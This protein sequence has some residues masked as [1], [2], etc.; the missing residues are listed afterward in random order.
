MKKTVVLLILVILFF[1]C[2]SKQE[3][4]PSKDFTLEYSLPELKLPFGNISTENLDGTFFTKWDE[5]IFTATNILRE[6]NLQIF[7]QDPDNEF[8]LVNSGNRNI[9]SL[10]FY[11]DKFF[12]ANIYVSYYSNIR[13]EYKIQYETLVDMLTEKYGIPYIKSDTSN[14]WKFKNDSTIHISY[15]I[16][17]SDT[18]IFYLNYRNDTIYKEKLDRENMNILQNTIDIIL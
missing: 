18:M 7:Y 14:V 8:I 6:N 1:S 10:R 4:T 5:N 9:I 2:T 13:N 16:D 11:E 12:E 3:I 15:F 17:T